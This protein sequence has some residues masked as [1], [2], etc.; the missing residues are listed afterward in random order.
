[1]TKLSPDVIPK[2]RLSAYH[3]WELAS[4]HGADEGAAGR[5]PDDGASVLRAQAQAEGTAAGY[6]A[7]IAQ[8]AADRAR[9]T[10]LLAVLGTE[11][12]EYEQRLADEVLD[13]ALAL[14]RQLVGEA[15]AVRR[16]LVLP[17]VSAALRQLPQSTRHVQLLLHPSDLQLVQSLLASERLGANCRLVADATIAPGGCR[18][19]TEQ[20]EIDATVPMRWG[21]LLASLGRPE[22][23]LEHA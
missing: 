7:G 13:L 14:A 23:W 2:E 12:A 19:E 4:L 3:R 17:V 16:E 1:V 11:V 21:R 22:D 10:A 20:C 18:V 6:A 15:I 5:G 9:L 8:A